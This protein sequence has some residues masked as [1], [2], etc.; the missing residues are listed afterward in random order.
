[1]PV[2]A[3]DSQSV[4]S[5]AGG[6]VSSAEREPAPLTALIPT[7][8]AAGRPAAARYFQLP[9]AALSQAGDGSDTAAART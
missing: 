5:A 9:A 4:P 7:R 8:I 2:A 1:M 3:A 6:H